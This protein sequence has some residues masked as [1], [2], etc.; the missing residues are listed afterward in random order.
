L[1]RV[2][3]YF[4][5]P[6]VCMLSLLISMG[7]ILALPGESNANGCES[8]LDVAITT[9]ENGA[10]IPYCS[11]FSVSANISAPGCDQ[12]NI[13]VWITIS[14]NAS[15][16]SGDDDGTPA[17]YHYNYMGSLTSQHPNWVLHCDGAGDVTITVHATSD[18]VIEEQPTA[19]QAEFEEQASAQEFTDTVTIHQ[20]K[21]HLVVTITS[22]SDGTEYTAGDAFT[23]TA[24]V[25]NT[26]NAGA[27]GV[28]LTA[29]VTGNA[30]NQSSA[31]QDTTPQDIAAGSSGT[32][33][34]SFQ[35]DGA[36][37][38]T[39]TVNA[40]GYTDSRQSVEIPSA[41]IESDTVTVDQVA[42]VTQEYSPPNSYS[43]QAPAPEYNWPLQADLVVTY[44]NAQ[45]QETLANSPVTVFCNVANRGDLA[46]SYT[47]TLKIDGQ[48]EQIKKG[49]LGGNAAKPLE[50]V[51]YRSEPGVY[52]VDLNGERT[53]FT[54]VGPQ[55]DNVS[56]GVGSISSTLV[57]IIVLGV[58]A[59]T[60]LII[61]VRRFV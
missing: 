27:Y 41:N 4:I 19:E 56:K 9:T 20:L 23:V 59:L 61:L 33:T 5:V 32:A 31:T 22:P 48:V 43:P 21:P 42:V 29:S 15:L 14:G 51:V 55:T 17:S 35:C 8:L 38:V 50:F 28:T 2:N 3:K 47:A 58:L 46:T 25:Q 26:G 7:S 1:P 6:L 40:A 44:L 36:G 13:D 11:N 37:S 53:F 52:D 18:P 57:V 30:S 24:Q 54:I 16:V 12:E 10:E 34:W 39:I 60:A 49:S 45:P